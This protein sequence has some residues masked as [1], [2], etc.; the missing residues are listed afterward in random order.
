MGACT[1]YLIDVLAYTWDL[2]KR[3]IIYCGI[4]ITLLSC[5]N[6]PINIRGNLVDIKSVIIDNCDNKPF[7][8]LLVYFWSSKYLD[9]DFDT[10]IRLLRQHL[11]NIPS[12][13]FKVMLNISRLCPVSGEI[14]YNNYAHI[15]V[16]LIARTVSVVHTQIPEG[17]TCIHEIEDTYGFDLIDILDFAI[18]RSKC[19]LLNT[20]Y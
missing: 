5:N 7:M 4:Y 11:K 9:K 16:D 20:I 18:G 3:I 8:R 1:E 12:Y 6:K 14:M 10:F 15:D 19:P 2:I 17:K 13:Q